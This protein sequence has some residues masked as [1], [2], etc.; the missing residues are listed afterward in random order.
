M[1]AAEGLWLWMSHLFYQCHC[2][3]CTWGPLQTVL[4]C[5]SRNTNVF[6]CLCDKEPLASE[7]Q[8]FWKERED[9]IQTHSNGRCC[10]IHALPCS[11]HSGKEYPTWGWAN[12]MEGV[13]L[14][15]MWRAGKGLRTKG[16]M[17]WYKERR[18]QVLVQRKSARSC[19]VDL[20]EGVG[21][22]Q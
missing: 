14:Q 1:R 11:P 3:P 10:T 16:G 15:S 21:D 9:G 13:W 7:L 22:R 19:L 17:N 2:V 5:P 6:F 18:K 12:S 4:S 20:Q 8:S